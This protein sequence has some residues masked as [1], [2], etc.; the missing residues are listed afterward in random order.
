MKNL[1]KRAGF[2]V[3]TFAVVMAV[4]AA[5]QNPTIDYYGFAWE[6]GGFPPSDPGDVL[7][8]VG[9]AD[10]ADAI[11]GVDLGADEL[12]FY[13]YDLVSTGEVDLG[14]YSMISYTGGMLEI[15]R[16]GAKNADWGTFPPNPTAPST[17]NDG[18][19]FFQGSFN[20]FT[21][22]M[23]SAGAGSYEGTL[24]GLGGEMIDSV[25]TGCA[26]TFGGSFTNDAGAQIPDG[27]DI[28]MDG[29]FSIE[30]AVPDATTS[31]GS[32]KALFRN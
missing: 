20:D 8:F 19:L 1:F 11:F 12:T 22:F 25:C 14:G 15:W 6:T 31:W 27:Y 26:Y 7:D 16:A 24:D 4:P 30:A 9:V 3:M 13:I 10:A 23:T 2:L 17:F 18:S 32:V 28:Q 5:A 29:V 21:L